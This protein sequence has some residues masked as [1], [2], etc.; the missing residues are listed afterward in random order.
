M[1]I[2]RGEIV[3]YGKALHQRGVW[4]EI[5]VL[6]VGDLELAALGIERRK[7]HP[8]YDDHVSGDE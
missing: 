4:P 8:R 5:A 3:S 6:R 1:R 7:H 2:F